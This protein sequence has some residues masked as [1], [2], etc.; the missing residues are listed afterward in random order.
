MIM[1]LCTA[2]SWILLSFVVGSMGSGRSIGFI[3]AFL[4]SLIFSPIIG[5]LIVIASDRVKE[6]NG[7]TESKSV[8]TV[9]KAT[10]AFHRAIAKL[11]NNDLDG[12][13]NDL[14]DALLRQPLFPPAHFNLACIY[15]LKEL[16]NESFFHLQKA[17]EQ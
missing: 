4:L 12:A 9:S 5:I 17:I 11:N 8:T 13:R 16:K 6:E 1:F 3:G 14:Q 15:S 7:G 2:V 10:E